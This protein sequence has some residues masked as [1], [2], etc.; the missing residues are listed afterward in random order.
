M[1]F[2]DFIKE[3]GGVRD[4]NGFV[5]EGRKSTQSFFPLARASSRISVRG[6][7]AEPSSICAHIGLAGEGDYLILDADS[8]EVLIMEGGNH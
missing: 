7:I 5:E 3:N 2:L 4:V 8:G 6:Q 1:G